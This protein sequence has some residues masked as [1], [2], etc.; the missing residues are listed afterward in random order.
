MINPLACKISCVSENELN[1]DLHIGK[2][3]SSS[4]NDLNE[5]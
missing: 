4:L 5:P 3:S 1:S 2:S